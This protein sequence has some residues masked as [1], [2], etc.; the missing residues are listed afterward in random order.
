[1]GLRDGFLSSCSGADGAA[2]HAPRGRKAPGAG[3]GYLCQRRRYRPSRWVG[4]HARVRGPLVAGTGDSGVGAE[5]GAEVGVGAMGGE[6][7][8]AGTTRGGAGGG[9]GAGIAGRV[10]V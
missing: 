3:P 2:R 10:A 5:V 9:G 8:G 6:A 4:T 1:M 7:D